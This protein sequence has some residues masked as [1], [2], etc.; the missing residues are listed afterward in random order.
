MER[1]TL[2][3]LLGATGSTS[4]AGCSTAKSLVRTG[5]PYFEEVSIESPSEVRV[6]EEFSLTVSAK[7]TGGRKGNFST[8]LTAGQGVFSS[9]SSVTIEGIPVGKTGSIEVGPIRF[10]GAASYDFRITDYDTSHTVEALARTQNVGSSYESHSGISVSVDETAVKGTYST[11]DGNAIPDSGNV[12]LFLKVSARNNGN[13][14][15]TLPSGSLTL[16]V[17]GQPVE[18]ADVPLPGDMSQEYVPGFEQV[19]PG[20]SESGWLA[21]E[22]PRSASKVKLGWNIHTDGPDVLWKPSSDA[23]SQLKAVPT[24]RVDGFSVSGTVE[25]Y[26]PA[27]VTLTVSNEGAEVG[28]FVGELAAN[29]DEVLYGEGNTKQ[30][31][32]EVPG[33]EPASKTYTIAHPDDI[34]QNDQFTVSLTGFAEASQTVG[35]EIPTRELGNSHTTPSGIEVS[36]DDARFADTI[37]TP[38]YGGMTEAYR[39]SDEKFL[40]FKVRSKI[41]ADSSLDLAWASEFSP[42]SSSTDLGYVSRVV[43]T[44][45]TEW[46]DEIDVD[47]SGPV[48]VGRHEATPGTLRIGWVVVKVPRSLSMNELSLRWGAGR[49]LGPGFKNHLE[50]IWQL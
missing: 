4:L 11:F 36:V 25:R 29:G 22:V 19:S 44:F 1:R 43:P 26:Q 8:T 40:V 42:F 50:A 30:V 49:H 15:T 27:E 21:F 16:H 35:I 5:P 10:D 28:K 6:G 47:V 39:A 48:Y 9:D 20:V 12:F 3:S 37:L 24:F 45:G 14:S 38:G 34:A 2:L 31:N 33:G 17:D 46:G 7:N 23:L 41:T 13:S 32:F 18:S